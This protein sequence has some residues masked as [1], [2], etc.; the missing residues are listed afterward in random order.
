MKKEDVIFILLLV[1]ICILIFI[2]LRIPQFSSMYAAGVSDTH[3]EAFE[4]G[5]MTKEVTADDKVVYRWI[6]THKIGY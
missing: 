5:L 2:G 4:M 1:P 6:E 3:K